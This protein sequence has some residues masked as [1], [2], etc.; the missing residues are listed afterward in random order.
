MKVL[1]V[2]KYFPPVPGGIETL[3]KRLLDATANRV[4]NVVVVANAED[5]DRIDRYDGYEVHRLARRGEFLLN[6][7]VPGLPRFLRRTLA[8][9]VDIVA[10]HFPNLMATVGYLIARPLPGP[11][12]LVIFYHSEVVFDR[13]PWNVMGKMYYVFERLLLERAD[14]IVVASPNM[15]AI[16]PQLP[17][18]RDKIS[19]VHYA[20][21]ERW[22]ELTAEQRQRSESIRYEHGDRV[23]LFVGRLVPYKGTDVLLSAAR[24]IRGKILIVGDGPLMEGFRNR[25]LGEGLNGKVVLAGNVADLKPYFHACDL[26]VLPSVSHLEA[27]GIVQMEAMAFGKPS[28][29]SDLQ[30]GVTY[31]NLPGR[32][33]LSFPVGDATALAG[34]V[35]R[36]LDDGELRRRL[37]EQARE[38]VLLDFSQ[39]AV[40]RKLLDLY[41]EVAETV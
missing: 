21:E 39:A 15:A 7:V 9:R 29:S 17:R 23:V 19:L 16:S 18:Y 20:L 33:G 4:E 24:D 36:L 12:K 32:T 38:R 13:F 35:N 26:L 2:G 22:T 30:T 27:F 40:G 41:T 28:V 25:I 34:A 10:L 5:A 31:I 1:H 37:G 14:R 8:D 3:L 6:P 11:E